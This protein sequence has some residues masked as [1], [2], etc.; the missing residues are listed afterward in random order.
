MAFEIVSPSPTYLE[1][2]LDACQATWGQVHDTYIIHDPA[3][4]SVWKETIFADYENE[5]LGIALPPGEVPSATF[6]L[7]EQTEEPVCLGVLNIRLRLNETLRQYGGNAG[8]FVR[9][10]RRGQGI[11]SELVQRLPDLFDRLGIQDDILLT[12]YE[13]N[14]PCRKILTKIRNGN[15]ERAIVNI[16]GKPV[17]VLRVTIPHPKLPCSTALPPSARRGAPSL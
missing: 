5:R 10:D 8:W 6:W 2:Y 9:T 14:T 12:C 3:A 11:A 4:C 1:A 15:L 13:A 7:I 17:S 16:E